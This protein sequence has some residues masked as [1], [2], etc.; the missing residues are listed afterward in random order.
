MGEYLDGYEAKIP[1]W[2]IRTINNPID[3]IDE[4]EITDPKPYLNYRNK[5]DFIKYYRL[6]IG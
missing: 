4:K 6:R 5:D 2:F 1:I 3:N